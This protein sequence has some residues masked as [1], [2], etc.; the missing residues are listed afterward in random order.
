MMGWDAYKNGID[1][2]GKYKLTGKSCLAIKSV[3]DIDLPILNR[4]LKN[5]G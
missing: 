1:H 5:L 3:T 2:I 4:V